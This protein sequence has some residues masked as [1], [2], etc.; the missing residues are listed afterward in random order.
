MR[1][2]AAR[3]PLRTTTGGFEADR[4]PPSLGS[5]GVVVGTL[6]R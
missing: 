5:S 1:K 2:T 4:S 6:R 3:G